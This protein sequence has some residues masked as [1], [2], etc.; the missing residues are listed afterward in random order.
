MTVRTYGFG[1]PVKYE[2]ISPGMLISGKWQDRKVLG[3]GFATERE[4]LVAVFDDSGD[5]GPL[6]PYVIQP[7]ELNATAVMIPGDRVITPAEG[8]ASFPLLPQRR[9]ALEGLVICSDGSVAVAVNYRDFAR[10]KFLL[11]DFDTGEPVDRVVQVAVLPDWQLFVVEE[12]Q[13]TRRRVSASA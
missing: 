12:G 1:L 9:V 13:T 11:L 10:D 7:H 8:D 5:E 4:T 6:P 3:L 2:E